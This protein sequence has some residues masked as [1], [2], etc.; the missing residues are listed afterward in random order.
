MEQ[1]VIAQSKLEHS[2]NFQMLVDAGII[3]KRIIGHSYGE[4]CLSEFEMRSVLRAAF[5]RKAR[6]AE[7]YNITCAP[8]RSFFGPLGYGIIESVDPQTGGRIYEFRPLF[9]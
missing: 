5:G 3:K 7:F 8:Q 4:K 9:Y 2:A 1:D 6:L